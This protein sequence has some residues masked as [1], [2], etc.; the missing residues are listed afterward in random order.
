M[1]IIVIVPYATMLILEIIICHHS[2]EH[3]LAH[4]SQHHHHLL[5]FFFLFCACVYMCVLCV[6]VWF[7]C[8]WCAYTC[9]W[10][11]MI[12]ECSSLGDISDVLPYTIFEDDSCKLGF[13]KDHFSCGSINI[14]SI[15]HGQKLSQI[16][17]IL[18]NN[19]FSVFCI[20]ESKLDNSK[21]PSCYS[22]N[23][24]NVLAKHRT[25][26]GG[27]ILVYVM[28]HI[29]CR[30]LT[31]IENNTRTLEHIALEVFVQNHC[32]LSLSSTQLRQNHVY[33]RFDKYTWKNTS[34]SAV[35]FDCHRGPKHGITILFF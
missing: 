9:H 3:L 17:T 6:Q 1:L 10:P 23:G 34:K 19:K 8:E 29:A 20:N 35:S 22:I 26:H 12:S 27:G 28:D 5:L 25:T 11:T 2:N 21:D 30:R 32:Q 31:E 7:T 4:H 16:E 14:N 33:S 15:L 24:Y 13:P 18:R